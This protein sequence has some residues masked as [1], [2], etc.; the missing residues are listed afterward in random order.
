MLIILT[1]GLIATKL[2]LIIMDF[3]LAKFLMNSV[4]NVF[5]KIKKND[6]SDNSS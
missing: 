6:D 1:I 4:S 3:I 2:F 5:Y